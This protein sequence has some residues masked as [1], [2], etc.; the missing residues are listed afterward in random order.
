MNAFFRGRETQAVP[1]RHQALLVGD[2]AHVG[3]IHE[4]AGVRAEKVMAGELFLHGLQ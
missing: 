1:A 3:K 4:V 2:A